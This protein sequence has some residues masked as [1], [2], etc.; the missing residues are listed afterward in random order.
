MCDPAWGPP[1][2]IYGGR[3]P[4]RQAAISSALLVGLARRTWQRN[5]GLFRRLLRAFDALRECRRQ[6]S[7]GVDGLAGGA[8]V[9]I[10]AVLEG[11]DQRG[12][13]HGAIGMRGDCAGILRRA[14]TESD[15]DRQ[16]GVPL[17]ADNG[18]ADGGGVRSRRTG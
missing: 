6:L 18:L 11:I 10:E 8:P 3:D 15:A 16:L 14:D 2:E 17:D 7:D 5:C 1:E 12:A 13:D 4:A 9:R